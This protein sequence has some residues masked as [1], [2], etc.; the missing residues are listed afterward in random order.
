MS[1]N[2]NISNQNDGSNQLDLNR[3][4][5]ETNCQ[6]ESEDIS[7]Q[8]TEVSNSNF[9]DS[10]DWCSEAHKLRQHNRE[11][12]KKIVQLEQNLQEDR[13][14]LESQILRTRTGEVTIAQQNEELQADRE[15]IHNLTRDV[16]ELQSTIQRQNILVETLSKQL[17][18]TQEQIARVER[19]SALI[20]KEY[21][22]KTQKLGSTEKQIDELTTRLYRQQRYTL[23][24]K[25]AL[26]ECLEV[27]AP[28]NSI[29]QQLNRSN[30][31]NLSSKVNAIEPW[32]ARENESEIAGST[33]PIAESEPKQVAPKKIDLPNLN[34][35]NTTNREYPV[36]QQSPSTQN[37]DLSPTRSRKK[38]KSKTKIDLP[39]L[40]RYRSS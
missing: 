40:P 1:N 34:G 16:D 25:A 23:E 35:N 11:L 13:E 9:A 36:P 29:Q 39:K 27:P 30:S 26:D 19:E 28:N 37:R 7:K 5:E 21:D 24:L 22:R 20:Q 31:S 38:A 3:N 17:E 2:K 33:A 8:E 6:T 18:T 32:S 10:I 15:Q 14:A 4:F 12:I